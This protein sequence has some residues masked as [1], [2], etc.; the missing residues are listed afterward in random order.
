MFYK[1]RQDLPKGVKDVLPEHAQDIYKDSFNAAY[2]EYA[3]P[4]RRRGN[5]SQVETASKVAWSAVEK[6][7]E[8]V[9]DGVWRAKAS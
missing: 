3:D 5:E 6:T 1:S 4:S 7:Y 2:T 9:A 8:K